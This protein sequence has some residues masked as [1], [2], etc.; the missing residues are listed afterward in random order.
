MVG[1]MGAKTLIVIGNL[2][3]SNTLSCTGRNI[4]GIEIILSGYVLHAIDG[5]TKTYQA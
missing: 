2:F 1:R 5:M 4:R 3:D